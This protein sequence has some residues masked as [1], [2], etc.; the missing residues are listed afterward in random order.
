MEDLKNKISLKYNISN[1]NLSCIIKNTSNELL[2]IIYNNEELF[3]M[4]L[5]IYRDK[6]DKMNYKKS[7]N[8]TQRLILQKNNSKIYNICLFL[9]KK[10]QESSIITIQKLLYFIDGFANNF[11]GYNIIDNDIESWNSGICYQ[12]I[13]DAFSYYGTSILFNKVNDY[14]ISLSKKELRYINKISNYFGIY[15]P[16]ILTKMIRNTKPWIDSRINL[17][18]EEKIKRVIDKNTFYEYFKKINNIDLFI[19]NLV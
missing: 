14:N 15:S 8:K 3:K 12:D 17:N 16:E 6:I 11:L 7:L 10:Y 4:Y 5:N 19:T 1:K 18:D 2:N 9:I 13:Y